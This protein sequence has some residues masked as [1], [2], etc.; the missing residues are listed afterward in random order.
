M[1]DPIHFLNGKFVEE[2][3]LMV[4]VR[5][6][7][8]ARGYAIFDFLV[9]YPSRR[10]FMLS[11]HIDRLFNSASLI[12]LSLPWSKEDV[13]GWVI[14]TLATNNEGGEKQVKI[15]VSGGRSDS[16]LPSSK[17]PTIA[18]VVDPRHFLPGEYYEQGAGIIMDKHT[19][20]S[21]GAKTNNYIEG[22]KEAQ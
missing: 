17:I 3:D 21:P 2:K 15:T 12:G 7:G 20:Y 4:S 5:D 16:L 1:K 8:F 19:R 13:K 10:P 11:K 22:V 18:I 6:L 14:Q 9:T